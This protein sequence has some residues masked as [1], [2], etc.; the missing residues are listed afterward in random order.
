VRSINPHCRHLSERLA[1]GRRVPQIAAGHHHPVRRPPVAL[2]HHFQHDGLLSFDA[3]RV[4][5]IQQVNA[6]PVRQAPHQRQNLVEIGFHLQRPRA[7]FQR[8]CQLAVGDI[9]VGNEDHRLQPGRACVC[10]HRGRSV[11]GGNAPHP[12]QPQPSGLR[13]RARH[14]VVFERARGVETLVLEHQ[15]V[16]PAVAGS[17]AAF[18]HRRV[19]FAQRHRVLFAPERNELAVAPHPALVQCRVRRPPVSPQRLPVLRRTFLARIHRFHQSTA[20]RAIVHN[21]GDRKSRAAPFRDANQLGGHE[22]LL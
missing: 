21:F 14:T 18:E 4:D 8:L 6:Q 9:A 7:V 16:Q 11:A 17:P 15:P 12:P 13:H 5:R 3:E 22:A 2:I 20:A 10:R 1:E 19:P